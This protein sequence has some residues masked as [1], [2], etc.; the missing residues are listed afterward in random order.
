MARALRQHHYRLAAAG[1]ATTGSEDDAAS[2]EEEKGPDLI[3]LHA[4]HLAASHF[5]AISMRS[6]Y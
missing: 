1:G 2:T 5:L 6:F 3:N 4:Y